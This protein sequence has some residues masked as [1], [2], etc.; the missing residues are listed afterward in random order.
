[1]SSPQKPNK[2]ILDRVTRTKVAAFASVDERTVA[3][4][5]RG[6]ARQSPAVRRAVG[7]ALRSLGFDREVQP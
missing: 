7:D 1:M 3:K 4:Y 2:T 6:A 5:L